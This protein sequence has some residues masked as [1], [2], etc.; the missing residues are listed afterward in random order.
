[1]PCPTCG[2]PDRPINDLINRMAGVEQDNE[3]LYS[4]YLALAER[5]GELE[6][7]IGRMFGNGAYVPGD[8]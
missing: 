4:R 2:G 1:M 5:V 3:S 7:R 8:D 6:R